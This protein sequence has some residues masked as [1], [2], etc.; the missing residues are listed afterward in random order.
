MAN[1]AEKPRAYNHVA[2][3]DKPE[4]VRE[5]KDALVPHYAI[6]DVQDSDGFIQPKIK[7]GS[8]PRVARDK[9]G[10]FLG[11][12]V[13]VAYVINAEGN[14]EHPVVVKSDDKRLDDFAIKAT[15]EWK[16]DPATLK[17]AAISD[18]AGQEFN[19]EATPTE[20][21]TQVMEPTGGKV[22]RPKDWHYAEA[23]R[24][25]TYMWTVSREDTEGGKKRYIT[26]VRIQV[27]SGLKEGAKKTAKQF[28][29]DF[30]EGKKKEADKVVSTCEPKDQGLFTRVCLETEEGPFHI[31]YSCF[32][33]SNDLDVAAV[34]ISGTTKELWE[35]YSPAFDKM[36]AIEIIDMKR[37]EK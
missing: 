6:T 25:P 21:V 36:T 16:F 14:V 29:L 24:G 3:D 4:L 23:H 32:W 27:F 19:F 37:F 30:V 20:F 8:L 18:V 10:K 33:G 34:T 15:S 1:A 5:V 31:L 12:Y 26:G 17:G 11:G 2:K 28:I 9:D 35:V 13:L 7:A 22:S